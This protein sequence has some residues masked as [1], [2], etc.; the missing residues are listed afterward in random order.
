M[1]S[2]SSQPLRAEAAWGLR[3]KL[4]IA[5]EWTSFGMGESRRDGRAFTV[6]K[7]VFVNSKTQICLP[8][9]GQCFLFFLSLSSSSIMKHNE[10][11]ELKLKLKLAI[12]GHSV[13]GA[14]CRRRLGKMREARR[15]HRRC[16]ISWPRA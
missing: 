10:P 15:K 13:K 6:R 3:D 11:A 9:S 5:N 12:S 7:A 16:V 2:P 4:L 8:T 14:S 1:D